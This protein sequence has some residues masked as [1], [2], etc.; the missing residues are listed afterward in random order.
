MLAYLPPPPPVVTYFDT[1]KRFGQNALHSLDS[2]RIQDHSNRVKQTI[3][4]T[5]GLLLIVSD[6]STNKNLTQQIVSNLA[7]FLLESEKITLEKTP[8]NSLLIKANYNNKQYFMGIYFDEDLAAGYE[9]FL[10]VYENKKPILSTDG[11][12]KDV[13]MKLINC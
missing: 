8:E 10:N 3:K 12:L 13:F 9:C 5:D 4:L 6:I 2:V 7:S 11:L 1:K